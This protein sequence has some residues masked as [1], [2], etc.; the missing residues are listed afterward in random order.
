[1][2]SCNSALAATP[3]QRSLQINELKAYMMIILLHIKSWSFELSFQLFANAD[4]YFDDKPFDCDDLQL[5][6]HRSE[7]C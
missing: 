5:L 2:M 7:L 3:G 1:M 6:T 4:F